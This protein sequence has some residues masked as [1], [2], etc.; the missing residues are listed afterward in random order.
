MM[1][2][3]NRSEKIRQVFEEAG[4]IL[5]SYSADGVCERESIL[6]F[7]SYVSEFN[8]ALERSRE[9]GRDLKIGVIGAVKAGKSS[10]L[11][12]LLF[13]GEE[14][15]PKAATPMT[16]ALTRITYAQNPS[17]TI[18]FYSEEDWRLIEEKSEEYDR[19]LDQEYAKYCQD[20][21]E[22]SFMKP[23]NQKKT[24]SREEYEKKRFRDIVPEVYLSAKQ[25]VA[26]ADKEAL[27]QLGKTITV[28]ENK[29]REY[30]GAGGKYV[31]VV[32]YVEMVIDDERL[33]GFEIVDTPGLDDPVVSRSRI[34]KDF[35]NKCDV[36]I[37][38]SSCNQFMDANTVTLMCERLPEKGINSIIVVG[39]KFDSVVFDM[40]R[41]E[42]EF[43][44]ACSK[45]ER[46][47]RDQFSGNMNAVLSQVE[48]PDD[49][50]IKISKIEPIFVSSLL[51]T[52]GEKLTG[53]M[54]GELSEEED[55]T[56]NKLKNGFEGVDINSLVSYSGINVIRKR[57]NEIMDEKERIIADKD[58]S[59]V[60]TYCKQ[61]I[62]LFNEMKNDSKKHKKDLENVDKEEYIK[63]QEVLNNILQ[64][65]QSKL[66][67]LFES[68]AAETQ[69]RVFSINGQLQIEMTNHTR[70]KIEKKADP[71]EYNTGILFWKKHH[72]GTII[73][74]YANVCD[75]VYNINRYIGKSIEI[76]DDEFNS[77]F[78]E[79]R[80][81]NQVK[82]LMVETMR[83]YDVELEAED[84]LIPLGKT[85][86]MIK[87]PQVSIEPT[88]YVDEVKTRFASGG[89]KNDEISKLGLLQSDMMTEVFND[90][91]KE[92][93]KCAST[94]K[95]VLIK[96]ADSF[97][98]DTKEVM[99]REKAKI[100]KEWAN[101]EKYI[102]LNNSFI[103]E[104]DHLI[105]KMEE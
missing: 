64:K 100:E 83:K 56:V 63:K 32:S 24:M 36:V 104:I 62:K 39:S 71:Y 103:D 11:N 2:K 80:L 33:K 50:L 81:K 98:N 102:E 59:V 29:L 45:A 67:S 37:L 17:A 75:V 38:L 27:S 86:S 74:H 78:D 44:K 42:K 52:A 22:K 94:I 76:L 9:N 23:K 60:D 79:N 12:V 87:I 48:H 77:F 65:S 10:L 92:V 54:K 66:K 46:S 16:A 91:R 93:E 5:E 97:V 68:S 31:S 61:V 30:I 84:I 99:N 19:I 34:T 88:K 21:D 7:K 72:V 47:L 6:E 51:S 15:L 8:D 26:K 40:E 49:W 58:N 35:L 101:K 20:K 95:D 85:F 57:L 70:I 73:T 41:K 96:Q 55:H 1:N 13:G 25:L 14:R 105:S 89:V 4:S 18:H 3:D 28:D 43:R 90:I 53:K 69:K 82:T